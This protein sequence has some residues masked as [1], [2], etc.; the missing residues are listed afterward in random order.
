MDSEDNLF[1]LPPPSPY[2]QG[3]LQ[4]CVPVTAVVATI[5]LLRRVGR[6]ESGILWYGPR[7][8]AGNG[9]VAYVV[10]PRQ[11]MTWGNYSITVEALA[12]VVHHLPDDWKPLAQVHSHP[13]RRVEHSIHDDQMA[14]SRR[15]LSLVFPFYGRWNR[16]FPIGVGVHEW[17]NEYWH[18]LDSSSAERRVVMVGGDVR[19]EDMR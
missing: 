6:R 13:G 17:Q 2:L 8:F 18:L 3:D 9:T 12:E 11:R 19:V 5:A 7:N 15:A 10:A 14:S 4:L 16:R 1:R